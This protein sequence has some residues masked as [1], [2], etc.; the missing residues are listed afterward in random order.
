M[1]AK[2][3][4]CNVIL[5]LLFIIVV[6][7]MLI[8]RCEINEFFFQY[9]SIKLATVLAELRQ[10]LHTYVMSNGPLLKLDIMQLNWCNVIYSARHA[11]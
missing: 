5:F 1:R 6:I 2:G 11:I 10:D 4:G 8:E 7:C 3:A 9:K